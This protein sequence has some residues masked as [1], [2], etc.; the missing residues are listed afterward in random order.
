MRHDGLRRFGRAI[1]PR[2]VDGV[3]V[4]NDECGAGLRGGFGQLVERVGRHQARVVA[5]L[6]S[7]QR[8]LGEPSERAGINEVAHIEQLGRQLLFHLKGVAAVDEDDGGFLEHEGSAR[9]AREARRPGEA[10]I[11]GGQVFV[12]VFVVVRNVEAVEPGFLQRRAQQRQGRPP[13]VGAANDFVC[14]SHEIPREGSNACIL[15][16]AGQVWDRIFF[17]AARCAEFSPGAGK[18]ASTSHSGGGGVSG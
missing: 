5:D 13:H 17:V 16:R 7:R 14:L 15:P 2:G 4:D 9:R 3:R 6:L 11:T 8:L 1:G 12:L 10:L 18:P